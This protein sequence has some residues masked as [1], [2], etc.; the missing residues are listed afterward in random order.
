MPSPPGHI[1]PGRR[2]RRLPQAAG[3]VSRCRGPARAVREGPRDPG[4]GQDPREARVRWG[5]GSR[6]P[7]RRGGA[8]VT[9]KGWGPGP[10]RPNP[11]LRGTPALPLF[12]VF[13]GLLGPVPLDL[14]LAPRRFQPGALSG[15]AAMAFQ[16]IFGNISASSASLSRTM[17]VR[18]RPC[19]GFRPFECQSL[20]GVLDLV[21]LPHGACR[22]VGGSTVG[23]EPPAS[24][25]SGRRYRPTPARSQCGRTSP[26]D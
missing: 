20:A 7:P 23:S 26:T 19:F 8:V 2:H 6:G 18:T 25:P 11:D 3:G 14:L 12:V 1:R 5:H 16:G 10:A 4:P 24:P 13:P 15:V 21:A 17:A 9:Q 22:R